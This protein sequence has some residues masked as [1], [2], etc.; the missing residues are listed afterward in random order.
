MLVFVNLLLMRKVNKLSDQVREH[1]HVV[2]FEDDDHRDQPENRNPNNEESKENE[3]QQEGWKEEELDAALD[4]A[5]R[6]KRR[7]QEGRIRRRQLE[8]IQEVKQKEIEEEEF[9]L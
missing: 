1:G 8:T 5:V 3:E 4:N 6:R 9:Q 2:V 7:S